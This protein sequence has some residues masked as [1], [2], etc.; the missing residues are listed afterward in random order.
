[1]WVP[2][3]PGIAPEDMCVA[4]RVPDA[5]GTVGRGGEGDW[6]TF[7]F[8]VTLISKVGAWE[9]VLGILNEAP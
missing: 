1:M 4:L 3:V 9:R 8:G 2:K 7:D 6:T 5:G